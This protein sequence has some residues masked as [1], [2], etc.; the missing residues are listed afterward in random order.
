M[1]DV[2]RIDSERKSNMSFRLQIL[3][4]GHARIEFN[5]SELYENIIIIRLLNFA[6]ASYSDNPDN[7]DL[8]IKRI[9]IHIH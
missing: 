7:P 5:I 9:L 3:T 2:N 4:H 8:D 1:H 6:Y